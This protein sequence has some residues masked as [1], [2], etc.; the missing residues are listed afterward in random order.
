[1]KYKIGDKVRIREDLEVNKFYN[2]C[3]FSSLMVEQMGKIVTIEDVVG[4]LYYTKE[5]DYVWTSEMFSGLAEEPRNL[6]PMIAKGLGVEV[7]EEFKIS[8]MYYVY[9][10]T[11]DGL[12]GIQ[13]HNTY[14]ESY[15]FIQLISG[16]EKI[17][18]LPQ[19]PKLTEDERVILEHASKDYKYIARDGSS[20]L[21]V[22]ID[23]P[24]KV[25]SWWSDEK[26]YNSMRIFYK[27]FQFIKWEDKEPYNIE[28]LLKGE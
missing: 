21:C 6:I 28:E 9:K 18:K 25:E 12:I 11:E 3:Y 16:K 20:A 14:N 13:S 19:K 17:I 5:L 23:N 8:N 1:M 15:I 24:K 26:T 22:Y 2:G 10:I 27:L 7:G 4:H